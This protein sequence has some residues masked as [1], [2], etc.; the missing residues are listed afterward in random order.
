MST[1]KSLIMFGLFL[2]ICS[3]KE[4]INVEGASNIPISTTTNITAHLPRSLLVSNIDST[5]KKLLKTIEFVKEIIGVVDKYHSPPPSV[6]K[7]CN[8]LRVFLLTQCAKNNLVLNYQRIC[9]SSTKKVGG[10]SKRSI[11]E[12]CKSF[13]LC[14]NS[15]VHYKRICHP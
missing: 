6:V 9:N 8:S 14:V 11:D 10:P 12:A 13:N 3:S 5:G 1:F 2:F 15:F 7:V 4:A